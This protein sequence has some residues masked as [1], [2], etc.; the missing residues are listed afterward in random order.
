MKQE[1]LTQLQNAKTLGELLNVINQKYKV[2]TTTISPI[3]KG[4]I[5][6]G[7]LMAV[8]MTNCKER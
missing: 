1:T 2:E 4:T 7:L 5:I 8:K 6:S 3:V